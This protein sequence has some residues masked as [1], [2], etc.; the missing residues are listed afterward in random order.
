VSITKGF[1]PA[2][3]QAHVG[4]TVVWYQ[5]D[6]HHTVTPTSGQ[7]GWSSGSAVL[8]HGDTYSHKFDTA[9]TFTYFCAIHNSMHGTIVVNP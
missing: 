9:G 1:S 4:Q 7:T 5:A 3:L 2:T 8:S 6:N